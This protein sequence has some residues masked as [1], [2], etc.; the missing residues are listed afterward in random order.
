[1]PLDLYISFDV[2][3]DG[4][5]PSRYS[6]LSLGLCV[7]GS[8]DGSEYRAH[9]PLA[10]TLYVEFPPVTE[11]HVPEAMAVNRLDRGRLAASAPPPAV[12]VAQVRD[13]ILRVS[14]GFQPVLVAY[15][16]TFD[17]PFLAHYFHEYS[18]DGPPLSF[19]RVLDL[20][21]MI[22][23]KSGASAYTPSDECLP[24]DVGPRGAHTHHALDDA[25]QQAHLFSRVFIWQPRTEGVDPEA[26]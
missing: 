5:F 24:E 2:E 12:G 6:M 3:A 20:R 25:I 18:D 7:A 15:P 14:A 23:A 1:L 8:Y 26:R 17:W 22:V 11:H 4:P 13:W 21:T 16:A 9:D 19:T 10:E